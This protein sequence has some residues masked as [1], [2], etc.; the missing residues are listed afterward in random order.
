MFKN[1]INISFRS[2]HKDKSYSAID[3]LGLTIGITGSLFML[4]YIMGEL[5]YDCYHKNSDRIYRIISHINEPDNAF[6]WQLLKF[7]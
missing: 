6:T 1:L 2:L 7:P 4:L 3:I 5:S